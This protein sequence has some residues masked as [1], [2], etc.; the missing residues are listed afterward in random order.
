MTTTAAA[1]VF[2]VHSLAQAVAV[3]QAAQETRRAVR[4]LLGDYLGWAA[5]AA[6]R[7][8]ALASVPGARAAWLYDPGGRAGMAA[9]A[10]RQG[11]PAV[12]WPR[13]DRRHAALAS[14]AAATG[15]RVMARPRIALDLAYSREPLSAAQAL[16][17]PRRRSGALPPGR[18]AR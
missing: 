6:L 2:R 9:L 3:L 18:P 14:L 10:L 5:C 11:A 13:R 7:D 8:A 17:A 4:I 16:L 12:L 1:P 15:G